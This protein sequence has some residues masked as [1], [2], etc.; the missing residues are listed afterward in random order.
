MFKR[1]LKVTE[2]KSCLIIGPR[3]SGKTTLLKQ[4]YPGLPY[5]TLDDLDFLQWAK[6]DPKGFVSK[7]GKVAIIDEIQRLPSL[8]V[9]VKYAIDN[10]EARF[11]MTGSSTVGLMDA[12]AD[13]LAGRIEIVSLP[14]A[15]WGENKGQPNHSILHEKVSL[16]KIKEANRQVKDAI[17][18]GQFPEVLNQENDQKKKELLVNYRNTY[19]TRDLMQLSNIENLD[20]LMAVFHHLIRSVGSHLDV[21]NFAGEARISHPT[22][23]KYLNALGQSQMT[24]KLYG[25]QYGP[26]KRYI[27]AAKT[28]FAD[29]GI[30]NSFNAQLNEGQLM[31]N[32]VISEFEKRR[33]LGFIKADQFYY[34]KTTAGNEIDLIFE[35]DNTIYAVEI[36]A[37]KRPRPKD[38]R[39]LRQFKD[40]LNRPIKRILF[41]SGE[42]YGAVDDIHLLPIGTLFQGQ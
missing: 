29:N 3:R 8:T 35:I 24:F 18:H 31:E 28:Y 36:K 32:F 1:W 7:L 41:Y 27:K 6:G 26:A 11:F 19:F 13:T 33:K 9:A 5:A 14:T 22:A 37:A 39:N 30:L 20:G 15:C 12:A 17:T 38:L 25:Y 23:K 34:Y 42:E 40:R 21:S 16:P 2:Q 10:E 4:Q